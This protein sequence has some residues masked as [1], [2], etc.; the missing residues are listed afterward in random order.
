M[1]KLIVVAALFVTALAMGQINAERVDGIIFG[2]EYTTAYLEGLSNPPEF[3]LVRDSDKNALVY[4]DGTAWVE[5]GSGSGD[6]TAASAF[7]T[8]NRLIK[9]DGTGKGV[10]STGITID[11][12]NNLTTLGNLEGET[13]ISTDISTSSISTSSI[14]SSTGTYTSDVQISG[15]LLVGSQGIRITKTDV[16]PTGAEGDFYADD[17]ENRPKYYDGTSWKAFLL[18]GDASGTDDQTLSL[19]GT[20]LSIEDGN[21]VDLSGLGG[22]STYAPPVIN[23]LNGDADFTAGNANIHSGANPVINQLSAAETIKIA[24][25]NANAG[26]VDVYRFDLNNASGQLDFTSTNGFVANGFTGNAVRLDGIGEVDFIETGANTGV[27]KVL[28]GSNVSYVTLDLTPPSISSAVVENADPDAVVITY[29]EALD[30]GN[31]PATTQ[32][33]INDPSAN[34]VTS[35]N[36]SGSTVT[37]GLTNPIENGDTVTLGYSQS[38]TAL[39]DLAGNLAGSVSSVSVTNNVAPAGPTNLHTQANAANPD[40]EAN[41]TTGWTFFGANTVLESVADATG[42]GIFAIR[43]STNAATT[44]AGIRYSFT[45]VSGRTYRVTWQ[46][47]STNTTGGPRAVLWSGVTTSPS[48]AINTAT[49][50]SRSVDVTANATTITLNFQLS[51][52]GTSTVNGTNL[53]V[54]NL[55]ITDITP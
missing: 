54:D 18:A 55:V 8:D 30:T 31:V 29:T 21:S 2:K 34:A 42:N 9:S 51:T 45:A 3:L 20:T 28:P 25:S 5:L 38:G 53:Y 36:I 49:Y 7:G 15:K 19:S 33:T 17:S 47:R 40:N 6:V 39:R 24:L 1:K 44:D 35:V 46:D 23:S 10:Q 48:I 26:E 4:Y 50:T 52:F 41:A 13:L 16:E 11:D 27:F 22:S 37:L 12:S 43:G 32:Y 14:V